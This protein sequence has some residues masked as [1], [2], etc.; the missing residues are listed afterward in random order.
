MGIFDFFSKKEQPTPV[1]TPD[2]L[3]TQAQPITINPRLP[4]QA[5]RQASR[6]HRLYMQADS[7]E[8]LD[9]RDQCKARLKLFGQKRPPRNLAEAAKL[10]TTL[11]EG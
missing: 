3:K 8:V 11:K 6:L 7:V 9:A 1:P 4:N 10:V 5:I 2:Q